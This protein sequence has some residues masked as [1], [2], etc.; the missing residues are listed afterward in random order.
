MEGSAERP[1]RRNW[2]V[3]GE[4]KVRERVGQVRL[5][6]VRRVSANA[7]GETLYSELRNGKWSHHACTARAWQRWAMTA[8]AAEIPAEALPMPEHTG[9]VAAMYHEEE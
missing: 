2:P 5:R 1:A 6:V 7:H 3:T 9:L 8:T 4:I